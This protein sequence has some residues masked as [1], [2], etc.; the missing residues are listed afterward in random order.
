MALLGIHKELLVCSSGS[1]FLAI[2]TEENSE[3][4]KSFVFD[5][6]T[7][8]K[9]S[10]ENDNK[11]DDGGS[12]EKGSDKILAFTFSSSGQYFSLT[13]DNKR[14]ILFRTKPIWKCLSI[15]YVVRRCT[16]L[17]ITQ[18]EDQILVADKSG[19]VYSFSIVEPQRPAELKL[20]HLSMLLGVTLSYNDKYVI[21]A[22]RDEKIRVSILKSPYNIES[23]CLGHTE[24][25]SAV[26]VIPDHPKQLLSGSGDGTLR[27]W[28]YKSGRELQC[29]DLR[30]LNDPKQKDNEK[31][32]A[33]SRIACSRKGGHVAVL[34]DSFP[35]V[36]LFQIDTGTQRLEFKE[37][38]RLAHNSWDVAFDESAGLWVL[39]QNKVSTATLYR[40]REGHWQCAVED[41]KLKTTVD[42]LS[43]H[44]DMFQ[45]SLDAESRYHNLY[46]SV[47]DNMAAYLLKKEERI[48]QQGKRMKGQLPESSGAK[49]I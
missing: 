17:T 3:A 26:I 33:V 14:L 15:R 10:Q 42:I 11:G 30:E 13:D 45:V 20:G 40:L 43:N 34:C 37:T 2:N 23:F 18:S 8:S 49:N 9:K 27:L 35:A 22:D 48:Q 25:V 12:E 21:T 29:W 19:D 44:W 5:C 47:F 39:Q 38:V 31:K 41:P 28:E 1:K 6:S 7:A 16:A 36:H 32:F 24:F 4:G 46:K